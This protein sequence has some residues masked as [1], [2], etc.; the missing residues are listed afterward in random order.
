MEELPK[1][2]YL[3]TILKDIKS[4][5]FIQEIRILERRGGGELFFVN[6]SA[7][8]ECRIMQMETAP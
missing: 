1:F 2:C 5:I 3:I 7:G 8:Y 4:L 6:P